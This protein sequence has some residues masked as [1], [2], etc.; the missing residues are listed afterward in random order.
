MA[1]KTQKKGAYIL[2]DVRML[3]DYKMHSMTDAEFRKYITGMLNDEKNWLFDPSE[4]WKEWN[5]IKNRISED[6]Y[7]R[8]GKKCRQCGTTID[9]IVTH[10]I[11]LARGGTNDPDNLQVLCRSCN[12]ER[13]FNYD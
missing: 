1:E 12:A 4:A 10:I 13:G 3:D 7:A 2:I 8:D 6:I 11:P 9:L 5:T